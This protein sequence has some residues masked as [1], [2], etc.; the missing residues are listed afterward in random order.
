MR[1]NVRKVM[2]AWSQGKSLNYHS[3]STNGITVFSYR[4]PILYYENGVLILNRRKYSST[5]TT[6]QNSIVVFLESRNI[7]FTEVD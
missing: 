4:T 5:T 2:T 6:Q 1:V 7:P 3:I